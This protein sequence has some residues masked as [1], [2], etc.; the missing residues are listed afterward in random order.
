MLKIGNFKKGKEKIHKNYN[1]FIF[2]NWYIRAITT[3]HVSKIIHSKHNTWAVHFS[4]TQKH[5]Y[6]VVHCQANVISPLFQN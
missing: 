3:V 1:F 4:L 2:N 5:L 6:G